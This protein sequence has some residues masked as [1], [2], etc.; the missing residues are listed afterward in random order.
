VLAAGLT[1]AFVLVACSGDGDDVETEV[2]GAALE[3]DDEGEPIAVDDERGEVAEDEGLVD[4]SDET[5]SDGSLSE[6]AED[7][8]SDPVDR[9]DP[10]ETA[11][12]GEGTGSTGTSG[13]GTPA[14]DGATSGGNA[15]SSGAAPAP[16]PTPTPSPTRTPTASPAPAP[17]P[18]PSPRVLT[19]GPATS[20]SEAQSLG[21]DGWVVTS[22]A[23][24][25]EP[26]DSPPPFRV[27]VDVRSE[28]SDPVGG[29][30]CAVSLEA[31]DDRGL[32]AEGRAT[33]T[34]V[35]TGHDGSQ[36][37]LVR[38]L[39]DLDVELAPGQDL[40]VD[41]SAPFTVDAREV[42]SATCEAGF[43]PN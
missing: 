32:V 30:V 24:P 26:G 12:V 34:L 42:A 3:R 19:A 11:D 37:R 36:R 9:P 20:G 25:V 41:P 28:G 38:Q 8:G 10:I 21:D 22:S 4:P 5:T 43:E 18:T 2:G 15:P 39:L 6:E 27:D 33:V 31:G 16:S 1:L 13:G 40:R 29:A 35:L 17:S 7:D 23:G 14:G